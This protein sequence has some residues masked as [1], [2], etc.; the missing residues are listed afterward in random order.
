MITRVNTILTF[1]KLKKKNC[2]RTETEHSKII[3]LR[4]VI[5]S[6]T[7]TNRCF[8]IDSEHNKN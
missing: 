3:G 6:G 2:R 4:L 8:I 5:R 7:N 1:P